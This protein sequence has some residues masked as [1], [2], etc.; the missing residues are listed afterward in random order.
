MYTGVQKPRSGS[1]I[2]INKNGIACLNTAT[3]NMQT[4]VST[5][6]RRRENERFCILMCVLLRYL[7]QVFQQ[8]GVFYV[9]DELHVL[10]LLHVAG[11]QLEPV[12]LK[13][14][15]LHLVQRP[16]YMPGLGCISKHVLMKILRR[17]TGE[18]LNNTAKH[19]R[20][21]SK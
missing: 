10:D 5:R 4:R 14:R 20:F 1:Y 21:Q 19:S 3:S 17:Q 6:H 15:Q 2:Y 7:T 13:K 12:P 11:Q 18:L 8:Q 9:A 16:A